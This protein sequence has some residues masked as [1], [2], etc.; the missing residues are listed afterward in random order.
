MYLRRLVCCG[1]S[2]SDDDNIIV[3]V[4]LFRFSEK[5]NFDDIASRC[6]FLSNAS[7]NSKDFSEQ[8]SAEKFLNYEFKT[9]KQCTNEFSYMETDNLHLSEVN[10][11]FIIV[12]I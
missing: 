3:L 5:R 10:L 7:S 8:L 12:F 6:K 4:N 11:I 2:C 1:H 9:E